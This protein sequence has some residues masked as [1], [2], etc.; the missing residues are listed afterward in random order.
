MIKIE[1]CQK[2]SVIFNLVFFVN[3]S[4]FKSKSWFQFLDFLKTLNKDFQKNKHYKNK[5]LI[6]QQKNRC[7]NIKFIAIVDALCYNKI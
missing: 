2:Y 1:I 4:L 5:F 6:Q 3:K 7:N